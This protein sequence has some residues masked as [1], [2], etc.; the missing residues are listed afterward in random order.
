MSAL[1]Q[2]G[3]APLGE[4][5]VD[6]GNILGIGALGVAGYKLMQD[7]RGAYKKNPLPIVLGL[8]LGTWAMIG[9]TALV[10]YKVKSYFFSGAAVTG[11]FVGGALGFAYGMYRDER[12]MGM[13]MMGMALGWGLFKIYDEAVA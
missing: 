6:W 13:G 1:V 11:M 7:R 8:G 12:P 4:R 2:Y 5:P 9:G 3:E 10:G